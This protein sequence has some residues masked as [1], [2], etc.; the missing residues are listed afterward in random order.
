MRKVYLCEQGQYNDH[1]QFM[2]EADASIP[3]DE[4]KA[5]LPLLRY[6]RPRVLAVIDGWFDV[7]HS[8]L[9]VY[10]LK[11]FLGDRIHTWLCKDEPREEMLSQLYNEQEIVHMRYR[12]KLK[13]DIGERSADWN[14]RYGLDGRTHSY[15]SYDEYKKAYA[16]YKKLED[17]PQVVCGITN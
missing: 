10:P 7:V 2:V 11:K 4:V 1:K 9:D 3:V 6:Y 8:E 5:M 15:L 12:M 13:Y 17:Q 14:A 16:L